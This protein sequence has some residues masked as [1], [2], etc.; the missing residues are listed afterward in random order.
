M[1][2]AAEPRGKLKKLLGVTSG[3]S[4]PE[5]PCRKLVMVVPVSCLGKFFT[6]R[7]MCWH[8]HGGDVLHL[9]QRQCS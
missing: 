6:Q 1:R 5:P 8:S 3:T 9:G 7:G 4:A 2:P